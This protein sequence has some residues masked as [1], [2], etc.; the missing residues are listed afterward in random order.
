[1][2]WDWF[3]NADDTKGSIVVPVNQTT[4]AYTLTYLAPSNIS[5][6]TTRLR[7]H[8]VYGKTVDVASTSWYV[9]RPSGC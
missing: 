9:T 7:V 6:P 2:V 8:G 1:V 4:G 5:D 3:E